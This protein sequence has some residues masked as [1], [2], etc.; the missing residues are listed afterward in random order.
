MEEFG[1][2]VLPSVNEEEEKVRNAKSIF[3]FEARTIDG[4]VIS[5]EKYR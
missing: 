2:E 4:E 3:E 1:T 5:L